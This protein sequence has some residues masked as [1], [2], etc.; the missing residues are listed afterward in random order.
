M[1]L[2][3]PRKWAG[4][5]LGRCWAGAGQ[6]L[7]YPPWIIHETYHS[8]VAWFNK[9]THQ[10]RPMWMDIIKS[11]T[12]FQN[13]WYVLIWIFLKKSLEICSAF[14]VGVQKTI[15]WCWGPLCLSYTRIRSGHSKHQIWNVRKQTTIIM[16]HIQPLLTYSTCFV[17]PI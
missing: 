10:H 16:N 9:R 7:A 4:K 15:K 11:P 17:P 5:M 13:V 8:F 6:M 14:Q 3:M 12:V 2:H 1:L